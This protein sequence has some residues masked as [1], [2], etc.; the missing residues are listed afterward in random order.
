MYTHTHTHRNIYVFIYIINLIM[1]LLVGCSMMNNNTFWSGWSD[2]LAHLYNYFQGTHL[3][4][5]VDFFSQ[6][7]QLLPPA[8]F[9][10]LSWLEIGCI[11]SLVIGLFHSNSCTCHSINRICLIALTYTC[12]GEHGV[13]S[14]HL[15]I[16]LLENSYFAA[17]N[18]PQFVI[19][20]TE[21][22]P[23][24]LKKWH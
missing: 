12:F 20:Q 1:F 16:M 24:I 8:S 10:D 2:L 9:H 19:F 15:T 22:L 13:S 21:K 4:S 6:Q 11:T 23:T 18:W 7:Q 17:P 3:P 5:F 14:V